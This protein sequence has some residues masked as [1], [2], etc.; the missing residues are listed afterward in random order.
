MPGASL[1]R[2]AGTTGTTGTAG[3]TRT[4]ETTG[5]AKTIGTTGTGWATLGLRRALGRGRA[6]WGGAWMAQV[7][8]RAMWAGAVGRC[9]RGMGAE[10]CR[11]RR[12]A[13]PSGPSRPSCP[14]AAWPRS[15]AS[16]VAPDCKALGEPR[17][18]GDDNHL[19][20]YMA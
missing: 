18:E 14:I 5:T 6:H 20:S 13:R 10:R 11:R 17:C 2:G 1:L 7:G 15:G 16:L 12:A 4:T 3:T 9:G 8:P 19:R